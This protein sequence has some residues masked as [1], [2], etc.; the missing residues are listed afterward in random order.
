LPEQVRTV[1][2]AEI[3]E[4][5]PVPMRE[6]KAARREITELAITMDRQGRIKLRAEQDLMA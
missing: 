6:V 3:S 2:E 4:S 5:G 1:V